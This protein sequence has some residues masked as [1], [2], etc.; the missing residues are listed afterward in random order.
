M[1]K[2][3]F[4]CVVSRPA[5]TVAVSLC[6]MRGVQKMHR[7]A[8]SNY[9]DKGSRILASETLQSTSTTLTSGV[10]QLGRSISR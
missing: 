10:T 6:E 3:P 1:R 2:N 5:S 8:F 7:F 9:G 4:D